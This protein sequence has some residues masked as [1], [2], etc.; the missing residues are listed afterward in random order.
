MARRR[1]AGAFRCRRR[2][3]SDRVRAVLTASRRPLPEA[4]VS[5][6]FFTSDLHGQGALYEQLVALAAAHRPA[7][8]VLGGDLAPHAAGEEGVRRQRLFL[9]GFFV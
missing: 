6:W 5:E 3:R 4:R 2:G 8:L 7:A 1:A 9:E